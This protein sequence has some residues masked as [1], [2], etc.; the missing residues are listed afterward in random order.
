[1]WI[2]E[3]PDGRYKFIERYT[4]TLTNKKRRVS[5]ILDKKSKQAEKRAYELL[6]DKIKVKLSASS[7]DN[8]TYGE[9]KQEYL[10]QWLPTVKNNT[11]RNAKNFD[12]HIA[13][14]M[15][16]DVIISNI[17]KSTIRNVISKLQNKTTYEIT[18]KCRKRMCAIF[19]YAVSMEYLQYNPTNLVRVPKPVEQYKNDE[20][21]FLTYD[22]MMDLYSKMTQPQIRDMMLVIFLT[23]MRYGELIALTPDKIDFKNKTIKINATYEHESKKLTTPKT[24]QSNRIIS[25]SDNILKIMSDNIKHNRMNGVKTDFIFATKHGNPVSIRQVNAVLKQY[26][27]EK[28]LTTHMFRHSHISFLAENNIPLRAIMDRV[29]H[30]N[31][32]TTLKIYSHTTQHTKE[33]INDKTAPFLPLIENR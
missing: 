7:K 16:D 33:L 21:K 6:Q 32:E 1:M 4:D 8:M 17:A 24:K 18:D 12:R 26:Y 31:P 10:D 11:I 14:V 3:L 9:L 22:E 13:S 23:G 29:G 25:V 27:P 2:E 30:T 5:V 20:I 28:H 19:N 15:S